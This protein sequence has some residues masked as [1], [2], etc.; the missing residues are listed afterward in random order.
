MQ[1]DRFRLPLFVVLLAALGAPANVNA[2]PSNPADVPASRD[3]ATRADAFFRYGNTAYAE[4]DWAQAE[5]AFLAA[6]ALN[7]TYDVA[8]NLGHAQIKLGKHRDAAENLS[9]AL[10]NWPLIGKPEPRKLAEER[11]AEA[12]T[13]VASL[14]IQ[15]KAEHA[16]IYVDGKLVG[17]SPLDHEV[18][19]DPGAHKVEVHHEV[20]G[21]E[22]VLVKAEKGTT[23]NV[24]MTIGLEPL[25]RVAET[26][27]PVVPIEHPLPPPPR[28]SLAVVVAGVGVAAV[29]L[30]LGI[31]GLTASSNNASTFES[32]RGPLVAGGGTSACTVAANTE[33]CS[34]LR[35]ASS[36]TATYRGLAV[37]GFSMTGSAMIGTAI[38]A[39]LHPL[40]KTTER[41][42]GAAFVG[43]G[44][45]GVVL[46][47]SF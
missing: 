13:F 45:G 9:F 14:I 23:Q 27:A 1:R 30:G 2:K 43:P 36:A 19:V 21:T 12:R 37:V 39:L 18:F 8:A 29:G 35:S 34:Q 38:Y 7:P 3:K 26:S 47:G 16:D 10:R 6:W 41:V 31:G 15:M 40:P 20:R 32:L 42:S 33:A 24:V 44:V 5:K 46:S 4:K 22:M 25:S 28:R 17:Q 11:L